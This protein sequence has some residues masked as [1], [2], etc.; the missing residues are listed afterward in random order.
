MMS[1]QIKPQIIN[2]HAY[3]QPAKRFIPLKY[4]ENMIYT[5]KQ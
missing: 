5:I 1:K 3:T 4:P 2:P